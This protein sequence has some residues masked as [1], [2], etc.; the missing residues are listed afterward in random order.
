MADRSGGAKRAGKAEWADR[1]RPS[2]RRAGF[3]VH[4]DTTGGEMQQPGIGGWRMT[5]PGSVRVRFEVPAMA[6]GT[7]LGWGLWFYVSDGVEV[8][9]E[10][11]AQKHTL[12]AFPAPD[13]GKAGSIW[14]SDGNELTFEFV[15]E[16]SGD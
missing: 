3:T 14:T 5:G 9:V 13:W 1:R 6:P 15:V 8:R 2:T 11:F 12:A 7:L 16:G 10:G 4:P